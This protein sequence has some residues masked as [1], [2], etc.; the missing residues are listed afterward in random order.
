M[1]LDLHLQGGFELAPTADDGAARPTRRVQAVIA[2]LALAPR[3]A[4]VRRDTLAALLWGDRSDAQA[5]QSVRQALS[6]IRKALGPQRSDVLVTDDDAVRLD[7][8]KL[9]CDAALIEATASD[10]SADAAKCALRAFR[11]ELLATIGPVTG[12]FDDWLFEA[13]TRQLSLL[14]AAAGRLA[15]LDRDALQDPQV[16]AA[17]ER[18]LALEPA[19]ARLAEVD[20]LRLRDAGQSD[21]ATARM[22]AVRRRLAE[23]GLDL[24]VEPS[25]SLGS[26]GPVPSLP[27]SATPP[28]TPEGDPALREYRRGRWS[29][30]AVIA[31]ALAAMVWWLRP[32]PPAPASA[33]AVPQIEALTTEVQTQEL[34]AALSQSFPAAI[35]MIGG[36]EQGAVADSRFVLRGTLE[37]M[38]EDSFRL[39]AQLEDKV[40]ERSLFTRVFEG[41]AQ[42]MRGDLLRKLVVA[43]DVAIGEG[44]QGR[45]AGTDDL[46]A[47]LLASAAI[48]RTRTLTARGLADAREL[49]ADALARD[50]DFVHA[51]TGLALAVLFDV[52]VGRPLARERIESLIEGLQDDPSVG[53]T[54]LVVEAFLAL[55]QGDHDTALE[56]STRARELSPNGA[57]VSAMHGLMLLQAGQLAAGEDYLA[58]AIALQPTPPA[59]VYWMQARARRLA[60]DGAGAV[61]LLDQAGV[62]EDEAPL[63]LVER[64]LAHASTGETEATQAYGRELRQLL[65]DFDPAEWVDVLPHRAPQR[66]SDERVILERSIRR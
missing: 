31:V 40:S 1:T 37:R 38:S 58:R 51:R 44:E 10:T 48:E 59:W 16:T 19:S 23:D 2:Y 36:I 32:E 13:R 29:R 7:G 12:P 14:T 27:T 55:S 9:S 53:S 28:S 24:E 57:E 4:P 26:I 60:G 34:A 39:F 62:A 41:S 65:P 45:F 33:L 61:A 20:A 11:G 54:A 52:F 17:L 30:V 46:E 63:Y 15:E 5:R 35:A 25:N 49:Y 50:P 43:T 6:Q 47:W 3:G 22:D 66:G 56:R 8:G 64:I 21:L 42:D 18:L